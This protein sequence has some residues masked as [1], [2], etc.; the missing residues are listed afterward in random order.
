[1]PGRGEADG[2]FS[3]GLDDYLCVN[4]L[5]ILGGAVLGAALL[6]GATASPAFAHAALT[7]SN[8]ADGE[9]VAQ[10]PE[11][12]TLEFSETLDAPSTQ[13]AVTDKSGAD[14]TTAAPE[15]SDA[16]ASVPVWLPEAGEYTVAYRLVSVDGHPID[17]SISFT[18][19]KASP[20]AE[21]PAPKPGSS[22]TTSSEAEAE[23]D[24]GL[25]W[26]PVAGA[27]AVVVVAVI[28]VVAWRRRSTR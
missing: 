27:A 6:I 15:I 8:P 28:A 25:G 9:T 2:N 22:T 17:G 16:T 12:I 3:A 26:W 20:S 14:V 7:G 10:A 18:S 4:R 1:M 11:S 5:R 19:Q 23:S 13:L 21:S 24:G